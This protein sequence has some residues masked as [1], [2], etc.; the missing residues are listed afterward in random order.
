MTDLQPTLH[1]RATRSL[2]AQRVASHIIF[3]KSQRDGRA[4]SWPPLKVFKED[5]FSTTTITKTVCDPSKNL[6]KTAN[7]VGGPQLLPNCSSDLIG[8]NAGRIDGRA[9]LT[10]N[11]GRYRPD[12]HP[13]FRS[14]PLLALKTETRCWNWCLTYERTQRPL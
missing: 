13:S 5:T 6:K 2:E 4:K 12:C 10:T 8:P 1:H 9:I 3:K 14:F 11:T 7:R